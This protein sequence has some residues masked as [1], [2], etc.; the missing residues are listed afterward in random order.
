MGIDNTPEL[1]N[2]FIRFKKYFQRI[3][4]KTGAVYRNFFI[5]GVNQFGNP[6]PRKI[7]FYGHS[8]DP[9]DS[10]FIKD[11]FINTKSRIIIHYCDQADYEQKVINCVEILG[12]DYVIDAVEKRT[13]I[14]T[15]AA[16]E[17]IPEIE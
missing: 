12:A 11:I 6:L 14:F 13:I 1:N 10:D 16:L 2:D 3:Q 8:L 5:G 17:K 9:I 15:D 4:K 7:I